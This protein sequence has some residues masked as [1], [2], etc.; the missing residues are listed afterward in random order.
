MPGTHQTGLVCEYRRLCSIGQVE[1]REDPSNVGAGGVL[2]DEQG[3]ADLGVGLR[4]GDQL[5]HLD[6]A[7]G[8]LRQS[9]RR[10]FRSRQQGELFDDAPGDRRGEKPAA[11]GDDPDRG[12]ELLFGGVFEEEAARARSK[13]SCAVPGMLLR[14]PFRLW[15]R[16]ACL[17][18]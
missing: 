18:R 11:A 1:L 13:V 14:F 12:E 3:R 9:R 16:Q 4:L 10:F 8:E 15:R 5:E 17:S 7:G 2:A 6:L